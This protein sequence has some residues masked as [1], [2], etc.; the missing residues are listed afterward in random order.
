MDWN[1]LMPVFIALFGGV[2]FLA[3]KSYKVFCDFLNYF[4][5][6]PLLILSFCIGWNL[7]L[8]YYNLAK[9][10]IDWWF[11]LSLVVFMLYIRIIFKIA[12]QDNHYRTSW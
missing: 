10:T 11:I 12:Q 4:Y 7:S 2:G 1:I 8:I 3:F 9:N 6:V 5:I